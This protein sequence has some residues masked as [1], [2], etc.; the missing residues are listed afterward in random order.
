MTQT[1]LLEV[2]DRHA[3]TRPEREALVDGPERVSYGTLQRRVGGLAGQLRERGVEENGIVPIFLDNSVDFVVA[4]LGVLAVGARPLPL[5][6][7]LTEAERHG[8][9]AGV[10]VAFVLA[11]PTVAD[12]L[13]T[14]G[15]EAVVG[16]FRTGSPSGLRGQWG[17]ESEILLATSGSTGTSRIARLST[18][19][20]VWNALAHASSIDL[21]QED[22]MLVV[23]PLY[24]ASTLVAQL[25]AGVIHQAMMVLLPSPFVPRTFFRAIEAERITV[26]AISPTH[27]RMVLARHAK[28]ITGMLGSGPIDLTCLR[29]ITIGGAP[30]DPHTLRG[31][32]LFLAIISNARLQV[33]YGL[34]EAGPRVT[35]LPTDRLSDRADTVG[36]P[37]DGIELRVVDSD[38]RVLPAGAVG[39]LEVCTPSRMI[40]YLGEPE[41]AGPWLA[42]GDLASLDDGGF[43]RIRGRLK[44]I[45]VAGGVN[46]SALEVEHALCRDARVSEAAVTAAPH[47]IYGEIVQAHVVPRTPVTSDELLE[48]L[49]VILAPFKLPRRI[50][51]VETLPRTTTGKVDK[52]RLAE[53]G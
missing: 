50:H 14:E 17:P 19:A 32:A 6:P 49:S 47:P 15:F 46:V 22:R 1:P 24:H 31:F 30:V 10:P 36:L 26:G 35:T 44:E 37:L 28:R 7:M 41:L 33:T 45:I 52:R 20:C 5:P 39:E 43:V 18:S 42:T 13:E 2:L 4:L 53:L 3:T 9:L 40:G 11:E 34:T 12:R 8:L 48:S 25:I 51:L 23:S 29:S 27:L 38:G 21:A 16:P